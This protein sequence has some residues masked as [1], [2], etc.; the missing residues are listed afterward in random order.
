MWLNIS[1]TPL[2]N[3]SVHEYFS[4]DSGPFVIFRCQATKKVGIV[5][6]CSR[7]N[8]CR[9]S[10]YH[11]RVPTSHCP[12][13]A[14]INTTWGDNEVFP[15]CNDSSYGILFTFWV[16]WHSKVTGKC[17]PK[18]LRS[19]RQTVQKKPNCNKNKCAISNTTY[20][21]YS[22]YNNHKEAG[23]NKMLHFSVHCSV[24]TLSQM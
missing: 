5:I 13:R 19:L 18:R 16:L 11:T 23:N 10:I 22:Q 9:L 12:L 1:P 20:W 8:F 2:A 4:K 14:P 17:K 6:S 7:P 15:N 21:I 3:N 24:L